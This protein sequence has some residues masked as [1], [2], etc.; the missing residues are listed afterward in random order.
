MRGKN[1]IEFT[2]IE[3]YNKFLYYHFLIYF[4]EILVDHD[5]EKNY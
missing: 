4:L 2:G 3:N 1:I 5:T